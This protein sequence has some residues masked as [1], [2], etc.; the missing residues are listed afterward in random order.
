[1]KPDNNGR[2]VRSHMTAATVLV[3]AAAAVVA[4]TCIE[5]LPRAGSMPLPLSASAELR[6]V[7][8]CGLEGQL[9]GEADVASQ[10]LALPLGKIWKLVW[11][12]RGLWPCL[13]DRSC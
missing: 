9:S 10:S 2:A 8:V 13:A 5:R 3:A 7:E 1:M 12:T 4:E 11:A 6:R